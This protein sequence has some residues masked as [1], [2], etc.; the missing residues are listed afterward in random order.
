MI[1]HCFCGICKSKV[2]LCHIFV[3]TLTLQIVQVS[4]TTNP[5]FPLAVGSYLFLN[6]G[7]VTQQRLILGSC[8]SKEQAALFRMVTWG[9]I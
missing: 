7:G 1:L 4:D 8:F 5:G 6:F 9:S 2:F 3:K